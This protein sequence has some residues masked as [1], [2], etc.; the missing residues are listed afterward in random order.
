MCVH[1]KARLD[2]NVLHC[3][4]QNEL[5]A[6]NEV[7]RYINIKPKISLIKVLKSLKY[8]PIDSHNAMAV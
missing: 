2:S 4:D 6:L 5:S 3:R 1:I 8:A 7:V